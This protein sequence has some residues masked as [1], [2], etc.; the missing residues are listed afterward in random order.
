MAV[1]EKKKFSQNFLSKARLKK[2][3]NHYKTIFEL[4]RMACSSYTVFEFL[5][6]KSSEFLALRKRPEIR[7]R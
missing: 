5:N 2:I 1:Y 7:D 3:D 6:L 4:V